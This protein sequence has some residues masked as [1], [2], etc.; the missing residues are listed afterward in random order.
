MNEYA[1]GFVVGDV[2]K[3]IWSY[4]GGYPQPP[5]PSAGLNCRDPSDPNPA[6]VRPAARQKKNIMIYPTTPTVHH[7]DRL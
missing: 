4:A 3:L 6:L 5:E 2:S 7:D 1:F